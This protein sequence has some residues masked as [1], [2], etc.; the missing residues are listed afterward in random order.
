MAEDTNN[1]IASLSPEQRE[2]YMAQ[3]KDKLGIP[4]EADDFEVVARLVILVSQL[5]QRYDE[6]LNAT[7]QTQGEMA[8]RDLEN[9]R[10]VIP[11]EQA[12]YW[13]AQLLAN[14][15]PTLK[16][17]DSIKARL[18][19][20]PKVVPM[21]NRTKPVQPRDLGQE[22]TVL[23]ELNDRAL[24]LANRTRSIMHDLNLPFAQA[25][26]RASQE[27]ATTATK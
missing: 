8:N 2:Q 5:Q 19:A 22:P 16:V 13:H 3:I 9:Y 6:V 17:L 18:A 27:L 10:D 23:K 15:E 20:K 24:L 12:D 26:E 21:A 7:A 11:P 14:R 4:A 25:W 1:D